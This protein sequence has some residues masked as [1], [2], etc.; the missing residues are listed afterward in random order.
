ML[1]GSSGYPGYRPYC[2]S[3]YGAKYF[4]IEPTSGAVLALRDSEPSTE[5]GPRGPTAVALRQD[6]SFEWFFARAAIAVAVVD[7]ATLECSAFL[8]SFGDAVVC[9]LAAAVGLTSALFVANEAFRT[10]QQA[11]NPQNRR[12]TD[13]HDRLLGIEKIPVISDE[14]I[15]GMS[16]IITHMSGTVPQIDKDLRQ[17]AGD[18]M[19]LHVQSTSHETGE[20]FESFLDMD[21]QNNHTTITSTGQPV[22]AGRKRQDSSV[23][24]Y[25]SYDNF[26][27]DAQDSTNPADESLIRQLGSDL[28]NHV[29][30]TDNAAFCANLAIP[31][32]NGQLQA[33]NRGYFAILNGLFNDRLSDCPF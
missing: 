32:F 18:V 33:A 11:T 26:G 15:G 16:T 9:G 17:G 22:E 14:I 23:T 3:T 24:G 28:W 30:A 20:V 7:A 29:L 21:M 10:F 4:R 1:T 5:L 6:N 27:Q 19:R 13:L 8:D 25:Y 2:L 31:N 12:S